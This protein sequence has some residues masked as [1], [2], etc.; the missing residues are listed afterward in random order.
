MSVLELKG[1]DL[2]NGKI[3]TEQEVLENNVRYSMRQMLPQA[4]PQPAQ[5]DRILLVGGGPSLNKTEGE[6]RDLYFSGSKI[7]TLNG[8]YAWCLERNLR[9]SFQI[10]MDARPSNARFFDPEIP[11]CTYFVASQV[12]PETVDKIK[13]RPRAAIFHAATDGGEMALYKEYYLGNVWPIG[14]GVTVATRALC[15]LRMLGFLRFDLFGIDSCWLYKQHHAFDQPENQNDKWVRIVLDD[16]SGLLEQKTFTCSPWHVKQF[17][18][19]LHLIRNI[20]H[21]FLLNVHGDGLIAYAL[22]IGQ[23]NLNVHVEE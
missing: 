17:E 15:L 10:V 13:N 4:H 11:N 16:T 23:D 20:G 7:V 19:F 6:L 18:D 5:P 21:Q 3:N 14:G 12:A 9:P 22:N 2:D 1:F 8:A